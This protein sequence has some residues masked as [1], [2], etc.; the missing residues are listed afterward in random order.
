MILL[1]AGR[2][3]AD[4]APEEVLTEERLARHYDAAVQVLELDGRVAVLPRRV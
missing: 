3:A 4:G 1:D 2:V